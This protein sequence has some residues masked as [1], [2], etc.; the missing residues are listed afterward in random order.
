MTTLS[1]ATATDP[2]PDLLRDRASAEA[3]VASV[4]FKHGPPRAVGTE[5]EWTVH[6]SDDRCRPIT[7]EIL[8][9]ALGPHAPATLRQDSPNLPLRGGS[10]V[11]VE[12]GG[13]VEIS[14]PPRSN[15][16][17]LLVS[18]S[19]DISHL[20]EL[21]TAAGLE[22]GPG[23]TDAHRPPRR[24]LN[25]PRYA[26]MQ[27]RFDRFGSD[28]ITMMCSTAGLQVC[29][30]MGERDRV[31]T[32][33]AAL[34]A[35]GPVLLAVFANSA[36][37]GGRS[38]PWVS[39]R[40]RAVLGTEPARTRRGAVSGDPAAEWAARVLDTPL[41]CWRHGGPDWTAPPRVTFAEWIGGA[42]P[43]VPTTEDM[44][45]HLSTMFTP[46]R[47]RGYFEVR[48]LD[49]QP[50]QDWMAPVALLIALFEDERV[51][52]EALAA[53][54]PAVGRWLHAARVGTADPRVAGAA[55]AVLDL[56]L[57]S[58]PRLGLPTDLHDEVTRS[59]DRRLAAVP[60]PH[61][62]DLR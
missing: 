54:Q 16:T 1:K 15:A 24:V 10:P 45:Y 17:D 58:L 14:S 48:Y 59:L 8:T 40:T 33:W 3:Y 62:G 31:A 47:P 34:H 21:L 7:A 52:D 57:R 37:L 35:L 56:G 55:R 36:R 5:I 60:A 25:T 26:A 11:T 20:T 43:G 41:I 46:I 44:D 9:T 4:C 53:A 28:G 38:T 18:T 42:L 49:S 12:P 2:A 19:S 27:A 51:V 30:D 29:L 13:Q 6:H 50:P 23:G 39:A 22:L 32:R 61:G